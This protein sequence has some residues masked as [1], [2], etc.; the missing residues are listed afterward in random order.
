METTTR[1]IEVA[2]D[3]T[4]SDRLFELSPDLLCVAGFD[5]FFRRVNPAWTRTLGYSE[6]EL[7]SQPF[8]E[9]VHPADRDKT[10]RET[11]ALA[12]GAETVEFRNRYRTRDGRYVWLE[13]RAMPSHQEQLIYAAARDI[14]SIVFA[15]RER[16]AAREEAQRVDTMLRAVVEGTSDAVFVKDVEGRY[17]LINVAGAAFLDA[18]PDQVVG[19]T[20]ADLFSPETAAAIRDGDLATMGEGITQT[21]EDV[22]TVNGQTRTYLSTKGPYRDADGT[23]IGLFGIARDITGRKEAEEEVQ[24]L[25]AE[26]EQRVAQ[27]TKELRHAVDGLGSFTYSVS[28]D[29]RA[30]LR[31]IDGFARI[32]V[33]DH[34]DQ[35]PED[36]KRYLGLVERNAKQMG[37]LIDDLLSFS[38]LGRQALKKERVS[39]EV[40]VH[41]ALDML[42]AEIERSDA[43]I[44]IAPLPEVE[45]DAGLL[46]HVYMN[47]VSNAIKFSRGRS[48]AEITVGWFERAGVPVFFVKDNGVGF[49]MTYVDK[50]FGVFQRLHLQDE[51]EGTGVGLALVQRIVHRHGGLVWAEAGP[52]EGATFFFTLNGAEPDA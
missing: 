23:V 35:L 18:T 19:R 52:D 29:L 39:T 26:L 28:H 11:G 10:L 45:A 3:P 30:P 43:R 36:A 13:W 17:L 7:L 15:E 25:N 40:V 14:T 44:S 22:G 20:D 38:R 49:D 9:F 6:R 50:L 41:Q 51:Y 42:R 5:G 1:P 24:R 46:R 34:A 4:A 37:A 33:E 47:L 27:R 2:A 48:P 12:A 8:I 32:L 21:Y 16:E 31:A